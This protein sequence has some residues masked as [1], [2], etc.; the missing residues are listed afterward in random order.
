MNMQTKLIPAAI[1]AAAIATPAGAG[2]GAVT[3]GYGIGHGSCLQVMGAFPDD[4]IGS[5]ITVA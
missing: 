4:L 1:L 3:R 2:G 5:N